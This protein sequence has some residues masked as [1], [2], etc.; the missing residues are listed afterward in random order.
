MSRKLRDRQLSV[1][2]VTASVL[3][4]AASC[5]TYGP[6]AANDSY[7]DCLS[8]ESAQFER[9]EPVV[10]E[11]LAGEGE[12]VNTERF[13][14]CDENETPGAILIVVSPSWLKRKQVINLLASKGWDPQP[15]GTTLVSQD[16]RWRALTVVATEPDGVTFVEARFEAR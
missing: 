8:E 4:L 7:Y 11:L 13:S 10:S 5:G 3:L 9:L 14:T 6:P 2:L 12:Q 15:D 1:L 16:G